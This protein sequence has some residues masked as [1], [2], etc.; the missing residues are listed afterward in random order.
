MMSTNNNRASRQAL[1][2]ALLVA[3]GAPMPALAQGTAEG[4]T[5]QEAAPA[6]DADPD[7]IIVTAQKKAA[8]LQDVPLSVAAIDGETLEN[9]GIENI[10]D[11]AQLTPGVA[12]S[13]N[14]PGRSQ[15]IIRGISSISGS[16]AT[17]GFY[18]D[19]V[20]VSAIDE[21]I[22]GSLFDLN[23]VEVLRGPQG[24][25]YG[26]ASMGGA[27]KYVSNQPDS[28]STEGRVD[29][30][31][32]D[33]DG[34][35]TNYAANGVINLPIAQDKAALRVVG[36]YK[37]EDGYIDRFA[38]DPN[39][40]LALD[41]T[42][43]PKKNV[44][45]YDIWGARAA[46]GLTPTETLRITPSIYY[47]QLK[48]DGL[49]SFDDPPGDYDNLIQGRLVP[50][51]AN[52]KVRIYNLTAAQE[53][54]DDFELTSSTSYFHRT[55]ADTEDASRV[56]FFLFDLVAPGVQPIAFPHGESATETAKVFT[57]EVRLSG[58]AG[59]FEFVVGGYYQDL[60][61][62][63]IN[64]LPLTAAFN[65]AFGSPFP[66]FDTLFRG[67]R[68]TK[69]DEL[70]AF[71]QLTWN[72]SDRLRLTGG[73][74][75]FKVEESFSAGAN[76][77]FNGGMTQS[78]GKSSSSGTTPKVSIDFDVNDDVLL[79]A[80]AAKGFRA[81]GALNP[82]PVSVCQPFL[83]NLGLTD[84]PTGF[85]PDSLWSYEVGAKTQMADRRVTL[86]ASAY[87]IDWSRIQQL[88]SLGCGFAFTA[89]F[90]SA[91]SRG[92]ELET[93]WRAT[94]GL[95]FGINAGY[96]DA[97]LKETVTGTEGQEGDRLL[98]VPK[99]T[100]AATVDYERPVS[101][102]LV[103][104]LSTSFSHVGKVLAEYDRTSMWQTRKSYELVDARIGIHDADE[105]WRL[106]LF[107][108]NLFNASATTGNQ[109]STTGVTIPT[110]RALSVNR[111]RTVGLNLKT[112]F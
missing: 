52:D 78:T 81:G 34:G 56:I 83:A 112:S 15:I 33:T 32:S 84:A 59:P 30:T 48:T 105:R 53:L 6:E 65:Q 63:R 110:T 11:I 47:Q 61:R 45:S 91:V 111:P 70:A 50:D 100:F 76:G 28:N 29:L 14:G 90:G 1:S 101:T 107:V 41:P 39:N 99:F 46:L 17:T 3:A 88:V 25:L 97:E 10:L 95:T 106:S 85:D 104:F 23:R 66:G 2:V 80:T 92:L 62:H 93:R 42:V 68:V 64:E 37:F 31:V 69:A 21:N 19:E 27:I 12:I 57:Q 36:F 40:Y 98:N 38:I 24:T 35:G 13:T 22:E 89:N 75:Q 18:L 102:G 54:S 44:N 71:G 9:K 67:D 94:D 86:N 49:F 79:Y 60:K 5:A 4:A 55:V 20:P 51:V 16:Q 74:R 87:H 96:N 82:V 7:E 43:A 108:D 72:I 26:S 58:E 73:L 8:N 103:G 109:F 77:V